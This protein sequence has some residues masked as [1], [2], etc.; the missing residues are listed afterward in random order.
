[1]TQLH[2]KLRGREYIHLASTACCT[3]PIPSDRLISLPVLPQHDILESLQCI[4]L[5]IRFNTLPQ[6][7]GPLNNSLFQLPFLNLAHRFLELFRATRAG[8]HPIT[9]SMQNDIV[10]SG[11]SDFTK[12]RAR[13]RRSGH[14]TDKRNFKIRDFLF[15]DK[16][17][18]FKL[19]FTRC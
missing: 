8:D 9:H 11:A 7:L 16:L 18:Y 19:S 4:D 17:L 10:L 12:L 13:T 14:F 5:C 2:V 6:C 3:C 1:M 15:Y